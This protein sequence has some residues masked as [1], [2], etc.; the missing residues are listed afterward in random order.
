M[1]RQPTFVI[2][3]LKYLWLIDC[4]RLEYFRSESKFGIT[5]ITLIMIIIVIIIMIIIMIMIT[6]RMLISTSK[7][8]RE[9]LNR[10]IDLFFYF[11]YILLFYFYFIIIIIIF[12]RTFRTLDFDLEKRYWILHIHLLLLF[13]I[14]IVVDSCWNRGRF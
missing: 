2:N 5:V 7:L 8:L 10:T 12:S 14:L 4:L 11:L 13:N 3:L 9:S 1:K 6:L